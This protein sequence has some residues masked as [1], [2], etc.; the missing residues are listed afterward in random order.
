MKQERMACDPRRAAASGPALRAHV[1]R[2]TLRAVLVPSLHRLC[3]TSPAS[4]F[5][6][7]GLT[8]L[9]AVAFGCT[10]P[11]AESLFPEGPDGGFK[12]VTRQNHPY[13]PIVDFPP[14]AGEC[15]KCHNT[16]TFSKADCTQ[17]GCHPQEITGMRHP[18]NPQYV[19][20][21]VKCYECHPKG[22]Y[23]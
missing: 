5:L 17:M 18:G 11:H 4:L 16:D 9:L 14:H 3:L 19:W 7:L 15:I 2:S 10:T 20:D 1:P 6:Q 22:M 13:F 8:L 23:P 21:S 12:G